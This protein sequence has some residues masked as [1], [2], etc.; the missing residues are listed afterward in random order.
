[1]SKTIFLP[2]K[3]CCDSGNI[4][5]ISLASEDG[6]VFVS[7]YSYESLLE[8]FVDGKV[9]IANYRVGDSGGASF[10]DKDDDK[11]KVY[12]FG[13]EYCMPFGNEFGSCA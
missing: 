1:M 3:S 10:V 9:I 7:D 4:L 2:Q 13:Y 5:F 8:A 6:T 12:I 11:F